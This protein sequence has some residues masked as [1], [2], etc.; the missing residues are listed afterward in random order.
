MPTNEDKLS[1]TDRFLL[2]FKV[3]RKYIRLQAKLLHGHA[4][5]DMDYL[6]PKQLDKI[7]ENILAGI[8]DKNANE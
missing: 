6:S 3:D 4:I 7:S 8:G 1:F 2:L 5:N